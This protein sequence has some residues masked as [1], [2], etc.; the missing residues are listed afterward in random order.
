MEADL[1][2]KLSHLPAK[3]GAYMMKD[4]AGK[5]IYVGKALSLRSRVRSYFQKGQTHSP[6][7]AILVSNI[8]DVEWIVTESE[9]EALMLECN[10]IKKH[11][12]R[13]NVRLR[14]DKH[15]PYVCITT[16]E[17]FP[18]ALVVRRV[19]PDGNRYFGPYADSWA[20]RESLRLIRKVF[21][22][23]ACNK[24]LTGEERDR[25]C[26]NMHMGQCESPCSGK[27]GR[28]EYARLVKD[29]ELFMG[30][31]REALVELLE[32]EMT[33]AAET[34]D[35]ERA[36]RLR[37][38]IESIRR[39]I[40]RQKAISTDLVDQDVVA[41]SLDSCAA[42]V[43][44]LSVRSG[45]LLGEEHFF[46]EGVSD[47]SA[48]EILG[49][50]LKQYYR[51]AVH[52]P[53][54][55]LV[56]HEPPESPVLEEWLSM[57]RGAR[58]HL[59]HPQ[60][61]EKR[62]LVEMAAENAALAMERE[63]TRAYQ[64]QDEAARDLDTLQEALDLSEPPDRIETY[65][66][67][68]IQGREAVGSMVV[69]EHGIPAK[70]QYRRF[71]IRVG[72]QPDDYGMMR[73]V[74]ARRLANAA[75]GDPKFSK[76]PDLMLID[77]GRGQLNAALEAVANG[78]WRMADEPSTISHQPLVISLAKR[79]EEVYLPD[80]AEPILLSR[81]S[82]A[83]RLLQRMRDEA[84]RFALAYHHKLREKTVRKS[85]LDDI[86]GIGD[87]RR[88]ALIRKFGSVAGV[89]RA[90]LDELLSVKGM[91]RSAAQAVTDA[92]SG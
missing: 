77:G 57:G 58:V 63:R 12:P 24:K 34:L 42:C 10:L 49:E 16:S 21:R 18:R 79:L 1:R 35:F 56:S 64:S 26:L 29:A 41:V 36:A 70:S 5:I 92:L 22:I 72:D 4:E 23:R 50:F 74:I 40:D 67:S 55:I 47:D 28:E 62:R 44:V 9:V 87:V 88:K 81:E 20:M 75:S 15:Y 48:E 54:E 85:L 6:R 61:G 27:I 84:H 66:I 2:A 86:P 59:S 7:T 30:G 46:L 3:P 89:R 19:K 82:P 13:Y 38:Q 73:E 14:D 39:T 68:N 11:R 69:F 71:K 78:E 76:L 33:N 52:V 91:T 65:D 32:T 45:R 17:P 60:R 53:R 51:D 37:D 80:R 8:R 25:P 31:R 90:T 83:L 43:Q